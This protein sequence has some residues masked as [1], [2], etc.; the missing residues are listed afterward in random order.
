M[1]RIIL[2]SFFL[3]S[4]AAAQNPDGKNVSI[5]LTPTWGWGKE[6]FQR[7]ARLWY[8]PTQITDEFFV[9]TQNFGVTK[10]PLAFGMHTM[11][12]VPTASFL[13]LTLSYSFQQKF[14]EDDGSNTLNKYYYTIHSM[15]GAYHSVSV[16][17][18]LYNLF[19]VY[20]GD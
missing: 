14:A 9:T 1:K 11:V 6:D 12:K 3:L 5:H 10:F 7:T 2:L 13:T 17:M 4:Y 19:S 15:N 18:S 8:P 16:T 20:Q